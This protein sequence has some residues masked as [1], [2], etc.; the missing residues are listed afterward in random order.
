MRDTGVGIAPEHLPHV[1]ERFFRGEAS[2]AGPGSGLG[3]AD[4]QA[5]R[6]GAR[7]PRRRRVPPGNRPTVRLTL[8]RVT[9]ERL[10]ATA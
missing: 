2:R 9:A 10:P 5:H 6:R 8:P 4:R 1:F 7:R 3:L